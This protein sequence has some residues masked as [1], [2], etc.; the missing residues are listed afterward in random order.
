MEIHAGGIGLEALRILHVTHQYRPALG[1]SEQHVI[2]VSEELARRGHRVDVYTTRSL[3]YRT[4]RNELPPR[5]E[6]A[7]VSIRRFAS[8]ERGARTY[9]ALELAYG[10][11]QAR[12]S[13][14]YEPLIL[15]G[16]GPI[17]LGLFLNVLWRAAEYDVVHVNTLPYA[18]VWYTAVAA[19]ARRTSLVITPFLHIDQAGIFDVACY[20]AALCRADVVMAMTNAERDYMV[21]RG[22]DP[23]RIRIGGVG[24]RPSELVPVERGCWR[25]RFGIPV[26]A[27]AILFLAR[28]TAYKGLDMV[29]E[30]FSRLR[31]EDGQSVLVLAGPETEEWE[32]LRE[33]YRNLSGLIDCGRVSETDKGRLLDAC[34]VLVLPSTGESFGIVF[35][36]AWVLGKPVIGARSGAV[37][38]MIA[39]GEDGLLVAPRDAADLACKLAIL[40]D[41]PELRQYLG[42]NGHRKAMRRYT[43]E[44]V[45]DDLEAIYREL[46]ASRRRKGG[47]RR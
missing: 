34:D 10:R 37:N 20:N 8:L 15:W 28:R 11:Y 26:K 17:S 19:A 24:V 46:A 5:E 36:E 33:R 23:A 27:F 44:K 18:H 25:S 9:R 29:L 14:L 1:G 35:V 21:S 3:D 6:I 22:V 43:V 4:W 39:E 47:H 32:A 45:S 2:Q 31:R 42:E 16:N 40:R 38:D 41:Q 12:R 13:V 30:A 7:G